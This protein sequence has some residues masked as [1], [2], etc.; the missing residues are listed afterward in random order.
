MRQLRL[1]PVLLALSLCSPWAAGDT[2][3][4][5][6]GSYA[7]QGCALADGVDAT[8]TLRI[9]LEHEDEDW[10]VRGVVVDAPRAADCTEQGRSVGVLVSR[11]GLDFV[12]AWEIDLDV[13]YD[14]HG[15]SA[16]DAGDRRVFGSVRQ[17]TAAAMLARDLPS[18][19]VLG[20]RVRPRVAAGWNF[21]AA[22]PRAA[23]AV[24]VGER[25]DLEGDCDGAAGGAYCALRAALRF[26]LEGD[27]GLEVGAEHVNGLQHLDDPF[28]GR[29]DA[30]AAVED[31]RVFLSLTRRL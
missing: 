21:G 18:W 17:T 29:A 4:A 27:W 12:G 8:H 6:G 7:A 24:R 30:P 2:L 1:P 19:E 15:V 23:L 22:E 16:F 14:E 11:H 25:L 26:D 13:G 5:L 31:N 28:G 20:V 3:V 10:L 9:A